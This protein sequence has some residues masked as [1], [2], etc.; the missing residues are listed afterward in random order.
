MHMNT[1]AFSWLVSKSLSER[2]QRLE[3]CTLIGALKLFSG[4]KGV[5]YLPVPTTFY[6]FWMTLT[7][8]HFVL[9]LSWILWIATDTIAFHFSHEKIHIYPH[10]VI[11]EC[12]RGSA[13]RGIR[14]LCEAVTKHGCMCSS[15]CNLLNALLDVKAQGQISEAMIVGKLNALPRSLM[16]SKICGC[17]TQSK[18]T[19][20]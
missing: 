15:Y 17:I 11:G 14:T 13:L 1:W 19:S 2:P 16:H 6:V 4:G 20:N 5:T 12:M 7:P 10:Y 3:L 8:S 18:G 9:A